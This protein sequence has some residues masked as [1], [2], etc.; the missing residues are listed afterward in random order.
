VNRLV[1][2]SD[3]SEDGVTERIGADKLP[4]HNHKAVNSTLGVRFNPIRP[5]KGAGRVGRIV[6]VDVALDLLV[7]QGNRF[8]FPPIQ[9]VELE[10]IE[11]EQVEVTSEALL[12]LVDGETIPDKTLCLVTRTGIHVF[13]VGIGVALERHQELFDIRP[14]GV[15]R[16]RKVRSDA[17]ISDGVGELA[18]FEQR[19]STGGSRDSCIETV[20]GCARE[21]AVGGEGRTVVHDTCET[22]RSL[23]VES[24]TCTL[25]EVTN[26]VCT[27]LGA[28]LH[29]GLHEV[30][31]LH[32]RLVD[33][34]VRTGERDVGRSESR[35]ERHVDGHRL[36]RGR[37][38]VK[39]IEGYGCNTLL[40][41]TILLLS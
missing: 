29:H 37:K 33:R 13:E 24:L 27:I 9:A 16:V 34:E 14:R 3:T 31:G 23:A 17:T 39:T 28:R 5:R 11:V 30:E 41:F 1:Y 4:A 26:V 19:N 32:R 12:V 22:H 36:L 35:E 15:I 6:L 25:E 7:F 10:V 8:T 21:T 38:L 20:V 2:T 40:I 18:D